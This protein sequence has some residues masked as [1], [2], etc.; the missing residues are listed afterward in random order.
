M[1][2]QVR[3]PCHQIHQKHQ[4]PTVHSN[5]DEMIGQLHF[6]WSEAGQ[7]AEIDDRHDI[8][9]HIYHSPYKCVSIGQGRNFRRESH[10]LHQGNI[11]R[12]VSFFNEEYKKGA[13]GT[14]FVHT[15]N[16]PTRDFSCS[17][18]LESSAALA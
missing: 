3:H 9:R 14:H 1:G 4:E 2:G 18:S 8:P 5:D 15:L 17:E 10:S 12:I 11:Q 6:S 16:C 13:R 7:R